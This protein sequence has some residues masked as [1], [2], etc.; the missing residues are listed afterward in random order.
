MVL[1]YTNNSLAE[2][3]ITS[4]VYFKIADRNLKYL[5]INSYFF[6][7][8]TDIRNYLTQLFSAEHEGF[9]NVI[10][11]SMCWRG[12]R[13]RVEV[14]VY[15]RQVSTKAIPLLPLVYSVYTV[16]L[17]WVEYGFPLSCKTHVEI[18]VSVVGFRVFKRWWN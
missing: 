17:L 1:V 16:Y 4:T 13:K 15:L 10:Q 9:W 6:N 18:I 7:S 11:S 8:E 12:Y 2:V 3:E 14:F 5:R